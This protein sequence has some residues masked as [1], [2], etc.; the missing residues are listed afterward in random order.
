M[1][2]YLPFNIFPQVRRIS[3][4]IGFVFFLLSSSPFW[5]GHFL[6]LHVAI[7][8]LPLAVFHVGP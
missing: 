8:T 1:G 4:F 3:E 2:V 7:S 5:T 6:G